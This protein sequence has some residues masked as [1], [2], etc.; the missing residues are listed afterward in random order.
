VDIESDFLSK[1]DIDLL[2]RD[3]CSKLTP[4]QFAV[5]MHA[6]NS[7]RLDPFSNQIHAVLRNCNEGTQQQPKWVTKMTVQ[8]GIDG[9]RLIADRTKCYAGNDDPV[10]DDERAPKRATVTVYKIVG[11]IRC[12]FT[13]SARWDQYYPGDRQGSM[14]KKM[15][16]LMLG[17]VAEALALR[18]AFPAELSG[19]YTSEE[20]QQAD[21]EV[22]EV[23]P[24][25]QPQQGPQK[26]P[27]QQDSKEDKAAKAISAQA[28]CGKLDALWAKVEADFKEDKEALGRLAEK[29]QAKRHELLMA[30]IPTADAEKLKMVGVEYIKKF[31]WTAQQ[32]AEQDTVMAN[33]ELELAGE[34]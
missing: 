18:K 30:F 24:V 16:P 13:A 20:M 12:P 17:K 21:R 32:R 11:N 23:P 1:E 27:Q 8:T 2:R 10:F 4:D 25:T 29:A 5:F 6:V 22:V 9:Y 31:S 3:K 7:Y 15:P 19:L 26:P 33:R 28:S 14:W 34:Q